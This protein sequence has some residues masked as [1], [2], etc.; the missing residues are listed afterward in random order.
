MIKRYNSVED[1]AMMFVDAAVSDYNPF[2]EV[3]IIK[4]LSVKDVEKYLDI[5]EKDKSVLSVILPR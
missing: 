5:F 4:N 2:D 1:I 3:E